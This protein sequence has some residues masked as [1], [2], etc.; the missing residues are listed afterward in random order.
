MVN[1]AVAY[2]DIKDFKSALEYAEKAKL[3]GAITE[4][5]VQ[6]IEAKRKEG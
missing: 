2:R 6:S 5:L 1:V 4:G 3:A